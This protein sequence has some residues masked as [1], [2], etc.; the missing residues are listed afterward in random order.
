MW[1][2]AGIPVN[3]EAVCGQ[4]LPSEALLGPFR[5]HG[6]LGE[7]GLIRMQGAIAAEWLDS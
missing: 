4:D 7:T 3:S 6:G 5:E 1:I 2:T